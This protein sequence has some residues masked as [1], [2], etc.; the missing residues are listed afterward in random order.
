MIHSLVSSYVRGQDQESEVQEAF[1][2]I[3][4]QW[5]HLG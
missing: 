4:L 3:A 2:P 5:P 1:S